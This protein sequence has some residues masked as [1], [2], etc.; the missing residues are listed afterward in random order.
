MEIWRR[1]ILPLGG[2][3]LYIGIAMLPLL[4]TDSGDVDARLHTLLDYGQVWAATALLMLS[5]L[6]SCGSY[7][8]E[9]VTG[10]IRWLVVRPGASW[11]LLP[12]KCLGI[13]L[14]NILL[15]LPATLFLLLLVGTISEPA[16]ILKNPEAVAVVTPDTLEA[17]EEEVE[18]YLALQMLE[19][20]QGWGLLEPEEGR[21]RA[22]ASIERLSRSILLGNSHDY[23]FQFPDGLVAGSR[24]SIR[25]SLGRVHRSERARLRVHFD[26]EAVEIVIRN[27]ERSTIDIPGDL[28][29]SKEIRVR[30]EFLG[31]VEE[32]IYIPSVLWSGT[33][34][35][36]VRIPDGTLASALFRSQFLTLI[37]CGF[38]AV[39]GLTVSTFLGMPVAT[40]FV[41]CF[42]IAAAGGGFVGA[43]DTREAP[44]FADPRDQEPARVLIDAL[45]QGGDFIVRQLSDWNQ[46]STSA[47][48]AAGENVRAEEV[49]GGFVSI[50]LLWGGVILLLGIYICSRQEHGLG[51]DR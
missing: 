45:A 44:V 40:L 47:R 15:L 13:V 28:V 33:D 38:I 35:M 26:G 12:G 5:L 37:R 51:R 18:T 10:R 32:G 24:M 42:L 21:R 11:T 49:L 39:L 2:G 41:L 1:G 34:A 50:G 8:D 36:Q 46:Y 7:C 43:F 23:W 22:K 48:V 17:T 25:P 30:L 6:M 16:T 31:A 4:V 14:A 9:V 27:G 19:D 20:P 29:G 3:L